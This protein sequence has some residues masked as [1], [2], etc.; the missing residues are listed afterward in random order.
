[1]ATGESGEVLI[2]GEV[3]GFIGLVDVKVLDYYELR[4]D[5]RIA[6]GVVSFDILLNLTGGTRKYQPVAKFP[7]ATRD[8]SMIVDEQVTW[9]QLAETVSSVDQPMRVA[10]EYITTYCGKQIPSGRKS[11]SFTLTYQSPTTTLRSEDDDQQIT[12]VVS[13]LKEQFSAELR[14]Q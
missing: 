10:L 2:D 14:M 13:A 12:E 8:L 3:A 1:M 9:Q 11:V 4:Q 6:A 7:A 5:R